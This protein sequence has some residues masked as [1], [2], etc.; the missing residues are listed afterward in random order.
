MLAR[1]TTTTR[2]APSTPRVGIVKFNLFLTASIVDGASSGYRILSGIGMRL[3]AILSRTRLVS[4][5]YRATQK[6]RDAMSRQNFSAVMV[7]GALFAFGATPAF[8]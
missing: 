2:T 8:A 4:A 5:Y 3:A 6:E 7:L 1:F